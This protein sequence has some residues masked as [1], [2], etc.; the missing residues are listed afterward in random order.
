MVRFK[1]NTQLY[2]IYKI[3][4]YRMPPVHWTPLSTL[5]VILIKE[6]VFPVEKDQSIRV[7]DPPSLG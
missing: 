3:L 6:M 4:A 7:V 1:S 2:T 5:W